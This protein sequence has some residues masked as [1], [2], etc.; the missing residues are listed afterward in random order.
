MAERG[1]SLR[2]ECIRGVTS[3]VPDL[4]A[5]EAAYGRWLG[6]RMLERGVVP[7]ETARAWGASAVA[8]AP[9][10]T[11][12]PLSGEETYLRFVEDKR[13][14]GWR[15]LTTFGWNVA[16]F[17]VQDVE[18]LAST[19]G[20]SPFRVIGPPSS[21]QRF[22]MIRAMQ[23]LG[24]A[25][26][27]LYF[28]QVGP[29][30]GL[31]LAAAQSFVGRV[32]IVVAGGPDLDAMFG[33]YQR[34]R[35][36]VDPPVSTRV[37]VISLLNRLPEDTQYAH[38]LVKLGCGTLIELDQY[39]AQARHRACVRDRLPPGMAMVSFATSGGGRDAAVEWSVPALFPG[40]RAA[41][42]TIRGATGELI[43]LMAG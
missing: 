16:E 6:Y 36:D 17:V 43:E 11:L 23:V 9:Y 12:G 40:M 27:C 10:V 35:N 7:A 22:P 8:G 32:F 2:L 41:A 4:D 13:A 5:I 30:S 29:G 38:G 20:G 24:P 21:L 37:R 33:A 34:F 14:G 19:F 31:D 25:G 42:V 28:T 18:A 1:E 3:C 39:P 15:A 26:E